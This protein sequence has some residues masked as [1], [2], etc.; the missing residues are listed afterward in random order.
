[1][2]ISVQPGQNLWDLCLQHTGTLAGL[3]D[4]ALANGLNPTDTLRPGQRLELPD[5]I[6]IDADMRDYFRVHAIEPATALTQAQLDYS[7]PK[8]GNMIIGQ[9][10]KIGYNGR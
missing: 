7:D 8:I 10:F 9:T 3:F 5:D 6:A 2:K 4:L 1:M